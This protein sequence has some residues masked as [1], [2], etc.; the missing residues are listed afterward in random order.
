MI[1]I[2]YIY[3]A[4][5]KLAV[6]GAG[7]GCVVMGYRLFVLGVM[8][9]SGSDIDVQYRETRLT[10]KN[11]APGTIFAFVGLAMIL[12]MLIQGVPERKTVHEKSTQRIG[13]TGQT[14]TMR[15]NSAEIIDLEKTTVTTRSDSEDIFAVMERGKQFEQSDQ[16]DKA[17]EIYLE[18]LKNENLSLKDAAE[19]LRSLAA[20][21]LKQGRY[22]EASAF[23]WL[24]D[25]SAPENAEGLAL[26]A[27]I[28]FHRGNYARAEEKISQ[29]AYIDST[30]GAERDELKDKIRNQKP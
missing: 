14:G 19:P 11:A 24:A 15:E 27:R 23:A 21:Y 3:A 1:D 16:F 26:I 8:P 7:F 22:D 25:Q 6:I 10:A 28:E 2:F 17:I 12:A 13:E 29:A 4:I 20:V 18:P 30:F 9:Q 5:Y